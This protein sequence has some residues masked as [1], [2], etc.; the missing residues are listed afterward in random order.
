[1]ATRISDEIRGI[2]KA[3]AVKL[4]VGEDEWCYGPSGFSVKGQSAPVSLASARKLTGIAA[5]PKAPRVRAAD[6]R[7][8][9]WNTFVALTMAVSRAR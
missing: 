1:M 2:G 3:L 9:E 7:G 8:G 4:G 6:G 5:A